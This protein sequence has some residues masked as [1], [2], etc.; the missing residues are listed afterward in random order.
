[1]HEHLG[2]SMT[3]QEGGLNGWVYYWDCPPE[4]RRVTMCP[5]AV[6]SDMVWGGGTSYGAPTLLPTSDYEDYK[7]EFIWSG[8]PGNRGEVSMVKMDMVPAT[9]NYV[10]IS[11]SCYTENFNAEDPFN[12][13]NS[14]R[15][16]VCINFATGEMWLGAGKTYFASDGSGYL[17]NKSI[18]FTKD[19]DLQL[20]ESYHE[21]GDYV[22]SNTATLG[23]DCPY[24][25]IMK[26]YTN[27]VT[28]TLPSAAEFAQKELSFLY[29]TTAPAGVKFEATSTAPIETFDN[30][31]KEWGDLGSKS[32]VFNWEANRK[33]TFRSN[34]TKWRLLDCET[35]K[36]DMFTVTIRYTSFISIDGGDS[37][38][39]VEGYG[40]INGHG[41]Q[42]KAKNG[43]TYQISAPKPMEV[44]GQSN[45]IR[46][47][48]LTD[49]PALESST[50]T[51][52]ISGGM[53]TQDDDSNKSIFLS[54]NFTNNTSVS[55][56]FLL[57]GVY[58]VVIT[59]ATL[60]TNPANVSLYKMALTTDGY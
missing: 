10:L 20:F 8:M 54:V 3:E 39:L 49:I 48:Y 26:G 44:V 38:Y 50:F 29:D 16:N 30:V 56:K 24:K 2:L 36:Y 37:Q 58:Q 1:M 42:I 60:S 34:G 59:A 28:I 11:D 14:F 40:S 18:Q 6:W 15:P 41:V 21:I 25:F 57:N 9:S 35:F 17:G 22:S 45:P 33:I 4:R 13:T 31:N 55:N 53:E 32:L 51:L 27:D 12:S 43:Y 52:T 23:N 19:G 7:C 47:V 5:S 46:A